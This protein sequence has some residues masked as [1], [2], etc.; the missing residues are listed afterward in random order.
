[1]SKYTRPSPAA[2][3][4]ARYNKLKAGFVAE[5]RKLDEAQA[6]TWK[7]G[8]ETASVVAAK[9][10]KDLGAAKASREK[11]EK[12]ATDFNDHFEARAAEAKAKAK[13]AMDAAVA[14]AEKEV[15]SKA[16]A[17]LKAAKELQEFITAQQAETVKARADADKAQHER[18][19]KEAAAGMKRQK[20]LHAARMAATDSASA[21]KALHAKIAAA[22]ARN[23]AKR[24]QVTAAQH[25][26]EIAESDVRAARVANAAEKG[27][28][29]KALADAEHAATEFKAA[30]AAEVA[31]LHKQVQFR[32]AAVTQDIKVLQG[33]ADS[34]MGEIKAEV[35]TQTTTLESQYQTLRQGST[36]TLDAVEKARADVTAAERLA[37]GAKEKH[38]RALVAAAAFQAEMKDF[39]TRMTAAEA[40]A[41]KSVLDAQTE[42]TALAKKVS[43]AEAAARTAQAEASKQS[44]ALAAGLAKLKGASGAFAKD[45]EERRRV[46]AESKA[47][48]AAAQEAS[49]K[50]KASADAAAAEGQKKVADAQ[51]AKAAALAAAEAA[52]NSAKAEG[53]KAKAAEEAMA[54]QRAKLAAETANMDGEAQRQKEEAEAARAAAAASAD[55]AV[56]GKMGEAAALEAAIAK[57][58]AEIS[59]AEVGLTNATALRRGIESK[60]EGLR[61]AADR[62]EAEARDAEA[63]VAAQRAAADAAAQEIRK[64]IAAARAEGEKKAAAAQKAK[65]AMAAARQGAA[66]SEDEL[67]S[68]AA[69]STDAMV[70]LQKVRGA[71]LQGCRVVFVGLHC[72]GYRSGWHAIGTTGRSCGPLQVPDVAMCHRFVSPSTITM[73]PQPAYYASAVLFRCPPHPSPILSQAAATNKRLQK[74]LAAIRVTQSKL[75]PLGGDIRALK[76]QSK[77]VQRSLVS[78]VADIQKLARDKDA[79]Q[80]SLDD[81]ARRQRRRVEMGL[82]S[83]GLE[84][85]S[86]ADR[87]K[88]AAGQGLGAPAAP[89]GSDD[90]AARLSLEPARRALTLKK[91]E[92][93]VSGMKQRLQCLREKA[94][95][96]AAQRAAGGAGEGARAAVDECRG[97]ASSE[98]GSTAAGAAAPDAA[99]SA[100][101]GDD[102]APAPAAAAAAGQA[103]G[104]PASGGAA[105]AGGQ[106][107]WLD[108]DSGKIVPDSYAGPKVRGRVV[109]TVRA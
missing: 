56:N 84:D 81:A 42:A 103:A 1:V 31:S 24:E 90:A 87:A 107:V 20:E 65:L 53:D 89:G 77:L 92:D 15:V 71:S 37:A 63:R 74:H 59:T 19:L 34:K 75:A 12:E 41:K 54:Q 28:L 29:S 85:M 48:L 80:A 66:A 21:V 93:E 25:R 57:E 2:P 44:N 61:K 6:K 22:K 49:A 32:T 60:L 5:G 50:A 40:A 99:A 39:A 38:A 73:L 10:E 55:S 47:K 13:T 23:A 102:E 109:T 94:A 30:T 4:T 36:A 35:A 108:P 33:A 14:A 72:F 96:A 86:P 68:N 58:R 88:L 9:R 97:G 101:A 76:R 105:G 16:A 45:V 82:E 11:V 26:A 91:L 51:A 7:F 83:S 98:P 64:R 17:A 69:A 52:K 3:D 106:R 67:E 8:N 62:A 100:S 104:G 43:E 18:L 46:A 27:R 79:L 95:A 70:K 78:A